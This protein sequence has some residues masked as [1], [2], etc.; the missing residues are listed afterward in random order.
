MIV[1]ARARLF[2]SRSWT[3]RMIG[4]VAIT[5]VAAQIDRRQ[6]RAQD[7]QGRADQCGDEENRKRYSGKVVAK[8]GHPDTLRAYRTDRRIDPRDHRLST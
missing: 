5:S 1:T 3:R 4:Q 8:V 2:H 6:E 7:P